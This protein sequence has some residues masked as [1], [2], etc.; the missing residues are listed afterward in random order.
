MKMHTNI[1]C[2]FVKTLPPLSPAPC[3]VT[4]HQGFSCLDC[5]LWTVDLCGGVSQNIVLF[6]RDLR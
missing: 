3:Y 5:G 2:D 6:F 4:Q 1:E